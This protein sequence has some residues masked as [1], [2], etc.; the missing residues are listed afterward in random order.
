MQGGDEG[1]CQGEA[2]G[3]DG[4]LPGRLAVAQCGSHIRAMSSSTYVEAYA[5]ACDR[6][7]AQDLPTN[8]RAWGELLARHGLTL[9]RALRHGP[10][11]RGAG[12]R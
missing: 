2:I 8:L 9:R 6:H 3:H 10:A 12:R 4:I 7:F 1:G 11:D 5:E